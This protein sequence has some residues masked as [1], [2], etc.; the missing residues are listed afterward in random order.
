MKNK[1][2]KALYDEVLKAIS[3]K[4]CKLNPSEVELFFR[5]FLTPK[6]LIEF[7]DRYLIVEG[8]LKEKTHREIAWEVGVSI[9]KIT[10]GSRELKFGF[11][12]QIFEKFIK[13]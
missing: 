11:G 3:K 12:K 6:E 13:I 7:C 9:S 4:L 2:D 8:L 10:S 1:K 5:A